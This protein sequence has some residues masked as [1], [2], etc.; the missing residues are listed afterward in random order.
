MQAAVSDGH[1]LT[2]LDFFECHQAIT[3]DSV[4]AKTESEFSQG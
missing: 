2:L 3:D 1:A 4:K